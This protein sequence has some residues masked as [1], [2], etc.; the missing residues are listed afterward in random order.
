MNSAETPPLPDPYSRTDYRRIIAWEARIE[1]ERP[2]LSALLDRSPERSVLDLGC[3]TG[4]HTAFFARQGAR[5]VG[6]DRSESMLAAARDHETRGEGRFVL[7]SVTEASAALPGEPPF[8]LAICLGNMLPHLRDDTGLDA[9]LAEVAALLVRGGHFL[10]QIL[11]YR[12]LI[13]QKIRH[14]PVNFREG[15]EGEEIVFLRL[16]QPISDECLLFFPTT[17][18]LD[19]NSEEPVTVLFITNKPFE[20]HY[21]EE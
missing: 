21:V 5:A 20:I 18:V 17:L 11:N 8:G 6:L 7:G 15:P 3:G 16:L 19:P 4:E 1:R 13:D 12:R 14:L 2:F 9:M 10:L